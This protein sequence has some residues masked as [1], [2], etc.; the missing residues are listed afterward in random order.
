[1]VWSSVWRFNEIYILPA[2]SPGLSS[3]VVTA[4]PPVMCVY[5]HTF[6]LL[7]FLNEALC[8]IVILS[9]GSL[10]SWVDEKRGKTR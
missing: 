4:L 2:T 9:D 8:Q 5:A 3:L 1:V 10:G 7:V 6:V